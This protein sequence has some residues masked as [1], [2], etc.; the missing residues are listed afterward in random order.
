MHA[1]HQT[2]ILVM[3]FSKAFDKVSHPRLVTKLKH[4]GIGGKTN[5]WIQSFLTGRTQ[6]VVLEGESS[7][8]V[9]V[10]SGVPQGSVLGPSLFLFYINDLPE[11]L[12]SNIRLFADDTILYLTIHSDSDTQVLQR[13]LDK[14]A[15]WEN[16][17]KMEFH[18]DKCEV[19]RVGRKRVMVQN[20]YVLHGKI[21]ASADSVKY[22]GVNIASDLRWNKHIDI[23]TSKANRTL[24]FLKRNLKI[25]STM[26]KTAAYKT[27]VRPTLEYTCT[28]WDPYTQG[29]IHK[30]E[31]VQRRAARFVLGR[32]NNTS[33]VGDMLSELGWTSLQTRRQALRL[34]M[35]FKI[36]KGLVAMDAKEFMT[37]LHR[38]SRHVNSQGYEVHRSKTNYHML[39]YFPR[40]IRE[41]NSLPGPTVLAPN[42]T[43][44]KKSLSSHQAESK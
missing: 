2:D 41:W 32:Y 1:G 20:D 35:M 27:L 4:Y 34:C 42:L 22:L 19:L 3:D 24:G 23:I 40:T 11:S 38:R 18:P 25:D 43:A 26:L 6:K 17:W 36:H 10:L 9:E 7:D 12:V 30:L 16:L 37:P 28:V 8:D 29:N 13:D 31:M 15:E 39:S 44:F 33:S 5:R 14:L 21:L